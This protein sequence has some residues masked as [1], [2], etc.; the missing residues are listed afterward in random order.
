[1]RFSEKLIALADLFGSDDDERPPQKPPLPAEGDGLPFGDE[2]APE[3]PEALPEDV[4]AESDDPG[5]PPPPAAPAPPVED[6][7]D[8]AV[9]ACPFDGSGNIIGQSDGSIKCEHCGTVFAV[10]VRPAMV[11]IPRFD[12]NGAPVV[13]DSF[14][15]RPYPSTGEAHADLGSDDALPPG[16]DPFADPEVDPEADTDE[17]EGLPDFLKGSK[18]YVVGGRLLNEQA[19]VDHLASSIV[20]EAASYG[21]PRAQAVQDRLFT[22]GI[23]LDGVGLSYLFGSVT[24]NLEAQG[25][26]EAWPSDGEEY[27][28]WAEALLGSLTDEVEANGYRV[29]FDARNV[30][31]LTQGMG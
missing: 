23:A 13:V 4:G 25:F 17:D 1:M 9:Y 12:E 14:E 11:G 26:V 31:T 30:A 3:D 5:V 21:D 18:L 10:E 22:L 19:Y 2:D 8:K 27:L 6:V 20:A 7:S 28:G 15:G 16:A 29:T 24:E